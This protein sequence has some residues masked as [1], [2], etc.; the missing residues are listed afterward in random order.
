MK[1]ILI[2]CSLLLRSGELADDE[3]Q[4]VLRF[5]FLTIKEW[6]NL[7]RITGSWNQ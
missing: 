3:R 2:L 5:A 6:L 7:T 4:A 1:D